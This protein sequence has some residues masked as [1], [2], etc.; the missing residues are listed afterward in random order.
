M[1]TS[2][3]YSQLRYLELYAVADNL[4]T[5]DLLKTNRPPTNEERE[6][7]QQSAAP[8]NAK[9]QDLGT[10]ISTLKLQII[11]VKAQVNQMEEELKCLCA[12]EAAVLEASA[13]HRLT[14]SPFRTLPND[15]LR[16]ICIACIDEET[17]HR[18][19]AFNQ[20]P[21]SLRGYRV[22]CETWR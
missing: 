18:C 8:F 16:E 14:L 10:Q 22:G 1:S 17:I 19:Q 20:C 12:Q 4:V 2:Y 11:E 5:E 21:T 6:I 9:L 13:A 15:I 7:I 3:R